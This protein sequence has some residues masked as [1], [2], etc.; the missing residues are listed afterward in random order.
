MEWPS[1]L[2]GEATDEGIQLTTHAAAENDNNDAHWSTRDFDV[3]NVSLEWAA[4]VVGSQS[5]MVWNWTKHGDDAVMDNAVEVPGWCFG[6]AKRVDG[7]GAF[8]TKVFHPSP[9]FNI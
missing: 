6:P 1:V 2:P 4:N 3:Y 8:Y 7:L 5:I 9:G